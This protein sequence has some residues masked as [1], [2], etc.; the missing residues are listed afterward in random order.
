M[1]ICR[2]KGNT[3]NEDIEHIIDLL[4]F[5]HGKYNVVTVFQDLIALVAYLISA[6]QTN[7]KD[8]ALEFDKR[9]E[10]YTIEEQVHMWNLISEL[11]SLYQKQHEPVDILGSIH[12]KLGIKKQEIGQFFTPFHISE[13]IAEMSG[14]DVDVI[15][16]EGF[17][18][19]HE[20][21]CGAGGMILAYVKVMQRNGYD[22]SRNLYVEAIDLDINCTLMT[23]IQ[24]SMFCI[25]ARV[26]NGDTLL[27][28]ENFVLYTPA[29][30][31]FRQLLKEGK[32]NVPICCYCKQEIQGE[33]QKSIFND[34]LNICTSCYATE[35]RLELL[36]KLAGR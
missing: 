35:R 12:N 10:T 6:T 13:A 14:I 8:S 30:F 36:K 20:P 11:A 4:Q 7:N 25:P 22:I 3:V 34:K 29:Y 26:E 19:I 32:L 21:A 16:K 9:M 17:L 23:Y 15:H 24:L 31:R 2:E 27:A 33:P 28:T 5:S 18:P 1:G